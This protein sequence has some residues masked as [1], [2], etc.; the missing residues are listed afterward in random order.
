MDPVVRPPWWL[1]FGAREEGGRGGEGS[2]L[3]PGRTSISISMEKTTVVRRGSGL[4]RSGASLPFPSLGLGE[5]AAPGEEEAAGG[6]VGAEES[7]GAWGRR[8]PPAA[9]SGRRRAAAVGGG[10]DEECGLVFGWA[11]S[12]RSHLLFCSVWWL[13]LKPIGGTNQTPTS[14]L[15]LPPRKPSCLIRIYLYMEIMVRA[16]TLWIHPSCTL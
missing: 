5:K 3:L 11:S 2:F 4:A 15:P 16:P 1:G 12:L 9:W 7:G 6:V 14:S 8:G 13:D 10:F